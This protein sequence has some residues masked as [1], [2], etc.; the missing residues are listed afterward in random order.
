M[1][2]FLV[3]LFT[4]LSV[5]GYSQNVS[6][7]RVVLENKDT[8]IATITTTDKVVSYTTTSVTVDTV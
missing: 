8:L 7:I 4:L 1:R 2:N 6:V 5:A 3:I